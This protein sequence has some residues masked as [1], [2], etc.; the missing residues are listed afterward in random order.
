MRQPRRLPLRLIGLL[1]GGLGAGT[2][3]T[4]SRTFVLE[5]AVVQRDH[6]S[7]TLRPLP[8]AVQA[9]PDAGRRLEEQLARRLGPHAEIVADGDL[10]I[11]YRF[12]LFDQGSTGLRLGSGVASLIGSPF[13][14]VG[15]GAIGVDVTFQDAGGRTLGRIVV[16]GPIAGAFG[17]TENGLSSA[18]DSIA[19]F[20]LA[21]YLE[22]HPHNAMGRPAVAEGP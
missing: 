12:S 15:D 19:K 21:H 10:V 13:Y 6:T 22:R 16:D 20:A 9:S 17:S 3:C 2:G 4:S 14:G 8:S 7:V 1:L 18:A 11:A 5:S